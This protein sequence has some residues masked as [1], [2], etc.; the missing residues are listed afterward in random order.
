[1]GM[2]V[3]RESACMT[4]RTW[5]RFHAP[6]CV[7]SGTDKGCTADAA[8]VTERT[9][10]G[11]HT[12]DD[13]AL[14]CSGGVTTDTVAGLTQ[15]YPAEGA[16]TLAM[17]AV[18]GR[19]KFIIMAGQ[20]AY[21]T[22]SV[23]DDI[24]HTG[25]AGGRIDVNGPGRIMTGHTSANAVLGTVKIM[26]Y[27]DVGKGG[28]AAAVIV[29]A[30]RAWL[31]GILAKIGRING[32]HVVV[33]VA[34]GLEVAVAAVTVVTIASAKG[35]ITKRGCRRSDMKD[36]IGAMTI[37]TLTVMGNGIINGIGRVMTSGTVGGRRRSRGR[38]NMALSNMVNW[39]GVAEE[40]NTS[41]A[42]AVGTG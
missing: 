11:M 24:L 4:F 5:V 26:L 23:V 9:V 8:L 28:K 27:Q 6:G 35:G 15:G 18:S 21:R 38:C 37:S 30:V 22:G 41:A 1:M 32:H 16:V 36:T 39:R 20:T 10:V 14:R 29:M 17:A 34:M 31:R 42:V 7:A 3:T 25:E 19:S 12:I 2:A 33:L 13:L 40:V